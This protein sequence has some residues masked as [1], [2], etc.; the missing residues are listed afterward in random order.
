MV[1][2]DFQLLCS[3]YLDES[4]NISYKPSEIFNI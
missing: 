1:S 3:I 4:S 2:F